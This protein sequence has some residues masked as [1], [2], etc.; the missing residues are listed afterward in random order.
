MKQIKTLPR[1]LL[2]LGI[3]GLVVAASAI[4]CDSAC[5]VDPLLECAPWGGQG[6]AAVLTVCRAW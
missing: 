6:Q 3:M 2:F 4:D 1:T 5:N